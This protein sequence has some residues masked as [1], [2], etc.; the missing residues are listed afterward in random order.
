M[1][2][3]LIRAGSSNRRFT[4]CGTLFISATADGSNY[5]REQMIDANE[6]FVYDKRVL[7]LRIDECVKTLL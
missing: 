2:E 7:W 3:Y 4:V 1:R 6:P 5:G